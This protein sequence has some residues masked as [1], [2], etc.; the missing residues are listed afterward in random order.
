MPRDAVLDTLPSV[1]PHDCPSACALLV[2]RVAPDRIGRVRGAPQP[3]TGGV[4]CAK[5]A[6]YA[7]RVHHPDRLT[8]PLL[9]VGAKGEGKFTPISW[10]EALDRVADGLKAAAA[11]HGPQAVWPYF[12]A[13]TMGLVARDGIERLRHVM[14]WSRQRKTVCSALSSAGWDAGVGARFGT[15]PREMALSDLIVVWGANPVNTQ[16]HVMNWVAQARKERGAKLVVVDPYRT[17]TAEKADLHLML[18]PGTDAALAC[19]VLHV[20]FKEG[21]ADHDWMARFA[22]DPAGLEA[23]LESRTPA[24]AAAITGVAEDDIVAFARLYGSTKRSFL[25][26]GYGFTRS[27]NGAASMHAVSCLPSVTGA[28]AH[29]GGGALYSASG[30]FGIDKTL[31]E[32]LDAIDPDTR[33]IDMAQIGRA[34]TGDA[35]ALSGGPPVMAMIV[36]NTNPAAIAPESLLVN[37]GLARDDLFLCVHEQFLTETAAYADVVLPATTF[38]EHDDLYLAG[39]HPFLQVHRAVIPPQGEARS[40]HDVVNAL[41]ERLGA[42]HAGFGLTAWELIDL[43][44]KASGY[45]D[46]DAVLEARWI[47]RG[48]QGA[49]KR[50]ADGFPQPDGK[51]HFRADWARIGVNDGR[52][53]EFPDFAPII[54]AADAEHPFR[55]VTAPARNFLNSTFTETPTSRAAEVRPTALVHPEDCAALGLAEGDRVRL[56]NRRATVVVHLRPFDGLQRGVVVVEG[57]WPNR[58]FIEGVGINALVGADVPA[59][60]GGAAYHDTAVWLRPA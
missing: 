39:A 44:L 58:A 47:D 38:L 56:G 36:Q 27:R 35:D 51:F 6:R 45:P 24:W 28:W 49:A 52:L 20:L 21:F 19:G 37:Q 53:P 54:E 11:V 14:G 4:V 55:L 43:T 22:D 26:T 60:A 7:E 8:R 17:A 9:R 34:L 1:C 40:N 31:I 48:P 18:R 57:I 10:D 13:G 50:F 16:V 5:V 41:A 30:G 46:A 3:Y 25:R 33:V 15:D 2:D 12:Y 23:H 42:R 32:G 59:P 29:E